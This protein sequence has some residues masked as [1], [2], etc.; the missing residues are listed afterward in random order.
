MRKADIIPNGV[1][2]AFYVVRQGHF[3]NRHEQSNIGTIDPM[4]L[5]LVKLASKDSYEHRVGLGVTL[6]DLDPSKIRKGSGQRAYGLAFEYSPNAFGVVELNAVIA[7]KADYDAK[8]AKWLE[9]NKDR[10]AREAQK[11]QIE[12]GIIQ[13]AEIR[14]Q[15]IKQDIRSAITELFG[16]E[17][18]EQ[19]KISVTLKN[20]WNADDTHFTSTPV[21]EVSFGYKPF[22][23][24][25][26]KLVEMNKQDE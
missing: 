10:L 11:K 17:L 24:V 20:E 18:V 4:K 19:T 25:M 15:Q 13:T 7:T 12:Q 2:T 26:A 22:L 16:Q 8:R 1:G 21:G 23:A 9:D 3:V 5:E 6:A 14:A